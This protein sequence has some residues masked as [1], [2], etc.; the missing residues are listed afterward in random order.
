VARFD[1]RANA[2]DGWVGEKPSRDI[3]DE[4]ATPEN[5]QGT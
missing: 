2:R 3:W 5:L 1:L 4:S